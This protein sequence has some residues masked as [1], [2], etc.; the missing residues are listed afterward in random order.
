MSACGSHVYMYSGALPVTIS[1]VPV[2]VVCICA[3]LISWDGG[4]FPGVYVIVV[5]QARVHC[6]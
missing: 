1:W 5:K 3:E 6:L 4:A 2:A